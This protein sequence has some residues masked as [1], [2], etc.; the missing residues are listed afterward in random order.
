MYSLGLRK[1]TSLGEFVLL[2][3]NVSGIH[4]LDTP[5]KMPLLLGFFTIA[6]FGLGMCVVFIIIFFCVNSLF[7]L[8]FLFQER[9]LSNM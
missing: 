4:D 9:C 5:G 7:C 3:N 6:Q 1:M 8:F 2:R